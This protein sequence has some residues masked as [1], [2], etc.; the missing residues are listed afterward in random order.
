MKIT[1][2]DYNRLDRLIKDCIKRNSIKPIK[3]YDI[4]PVRYRWDIFHTTLD[5]LQYNNIPDYLFIRRL[6]D[7][8]NDNHM[9]S[10]LKNILK[11]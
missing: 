8:L 11:T 2:E 5:W 4:S 7:Y 6:Y 3:D 1:K 10:A 9:D